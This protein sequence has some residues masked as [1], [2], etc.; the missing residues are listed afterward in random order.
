MKQY[1]KAY[2]NDIELEFVSRVTIPEF[3]QLGHYEVGD[4][5]VWDSKT[6]RFR[7]AL[8]ESIKLLDVDRYTPTGVVVIPSA[9]NVYS[10]GEAGI[11]AL[12]NACLSNPDKGSASSNLIK[13]GAYG[14]NHPELLDYSNVIKVGMAS[15]STR[16]DAVVNN[17]IESNIKEAWLPSDG[18]TADSSH[19]KAIDGTYYYYN[20]ANWGKFSPSSYLA[21]NTRNPIYYQTSSPATTSNALSD[22]A[23]RSNTEILCSK[24]TSQA[25]WKTDAEIL[26]NSEAGYHPAACACWR[27]HTIGTNQGDWYLPS[28]GELGYVCVRKNKI[29]DTFTELIIYF[30]NEILKLIDNPYWTSTEISSDEA[31]RVSLNNGYLQCYNR[32]YPSSV[33]PFTRLK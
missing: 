9:H 26:N 5:V 2:I 12:R 13:F 11:L 30:G 18:F 14:T 22:F 4:A 19:A 17:N 27:F 25:N 6:E 10:T 21:D 8:P 7:V 1:N 33:R 23:G 28:C 3:R 15:G 29:K 16:V 31:R 24:S 20:N 32:S